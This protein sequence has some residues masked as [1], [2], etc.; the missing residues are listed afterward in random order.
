MKQRFNM[1]TLIHKGLRH[2]LNRLVWTAGRLDVANAA[3]RQA[4]LE[5]FRHVAEMLHRHALD[6]DR[7]IQP[8]IDE[9]A[10]EVSAEMETQ[11]NRSEELLKRLERYAEEIAGASPFTDET[12]HAWLLFVDELGRFTGDYYL[13]LYH[14]ECVAMPALWKA[15]DDA[16]LIETSV[17]LRSEV[18][19]VIQDHFQRYMIPALNM[20][21]RTLL[22]TTLKKSAPEPV[23]R[24]A[25]R[26]FEKLLP[27][28]EWEALQSRLEA[29]V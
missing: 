24:E 25:C 21:E 20:Q 22:L 1:F 27:P 29:A 16:K 10:P 9:C 12:R 5:E 26:S 8:M 17:R 13:H 23:F 28:A 19:P 2:A 6:E 7:F 15:Y 14:E 18:P 3:E 11:H 4:F